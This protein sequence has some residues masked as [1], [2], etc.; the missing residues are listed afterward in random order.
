METRS[1]HRL[2][3]AASL[4]ALSLF[5]FCSIVGSAV[6]E[7]QP[8]ASL[9]GTVID[10]TTQETLVSATV[11]IRGTKLGGLT[12]KSGYFAIQDIPPGKHTVVVSYVG[13]TRKQLEIEF[14]S[15]EA[16]KITFALV[17]ADVQGREL[18]IEAESLVDKRQITVSRVDIPVEQLS[19]LR[20]GGEADVFRSLQYLPGVLTSSQ[21]S[22][23]LYIRG[24]SP[25]QNLV[26]IDGSTV[27]NP[28]HLLGFFSTFNPDAIKDV[29]LIKGGY[30]AEYGGRL[31]AVLDLTQKDGNRREFEGLASIGAIASRISLQ[32][33]VGNG[34]WFL[35]ARRT[36]LDLILKLVPEDP[37]NPLPNF[38][39]YDVNAKVTQNLS[40]NDIVSLSGF[41]SSDNLGLN[42]GGIDFAVGIGNRTGALR[43]NHIFGDN[44]FSVL[45][46]SGSHYQNGFDGSNGGFRFL[47][48]N[49][50]TDYTLKGNMEWFVSNDATAKGGFEVT[51][52]TFHYLQNTTGSD[53]TIPSGTQ[54]AGKTNL[55]VIDWTY[56][57]FGQANYQLTELLGLQAGLR[58]DH[59]DQVNLTTY[60]PRMAIR[61][62]FQPEFSVKLAWGIF[63][64]YLHLA[65][66]PDFS[67]FDTWLPT[68]SSSLPGKSDHYVIGIETKPWDGYEL[69]VDLYY[70][71]LE[72]IN[73]L[74]RT[75]TQAG[76]VSQI[77]YTGKGDAYGAEIFLQKR[78]G[79]LTG[80]LG[81]GLGYI[82]AQ[83]DSINDGVEFRPKYDR[84]HDL[85]VVAQYKLNE[86]WELGASFT[87]QSGQSYTGATSRFRTTLPGDTVASDIVVPSQRYGLRL[88]PS[89]QLNVNVNYISTLFGL[90]MRLL[91]DIF[92]VYSRRDIWFRYYDTTTD[93]T[94]VTDVRLL[95]IIPSVALEVKF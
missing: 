81:Y 90:P 53:T 89:H 93:E 34:A 2:H 82:T 20:I 64:Q 85:K 71:T 47:V 40:D 57:A 84:R 65:S 59:L 18:V 95:P 88:P 74:N 11:Q 51:N 55:T 42:G 21:L 75:N 12:N 60:D 1:R 63:H 44:L 70:K 35:G 45:N 50:I 25:D 72:N 26:L 10:S 86:H 78:E 24:G 32:G 33:P 41:L 9:S 38:N 87:F 8:S 76:S 16:K 67:F 13:Y 61:Y 3:F 79:R 28:S 92:N 22:S 80:W 36:Y 66:L 43:W 31:S 17:P 5:L 69:N 83:F 6:A 19:Q 29:E 77:F 49:T 46:L 7:P 48:E 23:G 4:T 58:V 52:Y 27:Y 91:I 68:D 73:E 62:Q 15:G 30:P 56:S 54:E 39:F 14:Q 37:A 94:E